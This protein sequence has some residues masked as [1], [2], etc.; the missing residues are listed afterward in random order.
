MG[1]RHQRHRRH[2][3]LFLPKKGG[4]NTI[5]KHWLL[6]ALLAL[7]LLGIYWGLS[8]LGK[9]LQLGAAVALAA[10]A[11]LF[12]FA[13]IWVIGACLVWAW[14]LGWLNSLFSW[15]PQSQ[16]PPGGVDTSGNSGIGA[17]F[18]P[19][20]GGVDAS[21]LPPSTGMTAPAVGNEVSVSDPTLP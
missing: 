7:F 20:P 18:A 2:L 6:L 10:G 11:I 3:L 14:A 5:K 1:D 9:A 12:D 21:P 8:K 16:N 19:A 4:M 17:T 13:W 15:F